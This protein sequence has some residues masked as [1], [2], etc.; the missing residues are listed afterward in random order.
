MDRAGWH[1]TAKLVVPNNLTIILLP[2]KSPEL[3][4][5]EN[6]WQYLRAFGIGLYW[7]IYYVGFVLSPAIAGRLADWTGS[8]DVVFSLGAGML[9]AC[10]LPVWLFRVFAERI[11]SAVV[12]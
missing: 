6:V 8:A 5:A 3:N 1:S 12:A 2:S 9:C 4:P 10:V 7:M 11:R